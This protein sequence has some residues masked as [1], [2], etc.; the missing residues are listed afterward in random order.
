MVELFGTE[1]PDLPG[2]R[3]GKGHPMRAFLKDFSESQACDLVASEAKVSMRRSGTALLLGMDPEACEVSS[4]ILERY[5]LETV[6]LSCVAELREVIE[7]RRPCVLVSEDRV[8]DG[9]F[10]DVLGC[11]LSSVQEFPVIVFSRIADWDEYLA[12]VKLGAHDLLRFPFRT[13]ELRWVVERAL[14]DQSE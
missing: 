13:G 4:D 14:T 5:G 6:R 12:A 7:E 2:F 8:A 3:V 10:R 9:D 11:V 1:E